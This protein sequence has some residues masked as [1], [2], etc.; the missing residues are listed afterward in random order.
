MTRSTTDNIGSRCFAEFLGT[1]ILVFAGCGAII[2]DQATGAAESGVGALGHLGVSVVFGLAVLAVIYAF[3]EISGAHINP[4]VTVAFWWSGRFPG[5]EVVPYALSQIAG[6]AVASFTLMLCLMQTVEYTTWGVTLP[7]SGLAS[8]QAFALETILTFILMTVIIHVASGS[9]ETGIMAG[10]AIGA[11]VLILA[12]IGGPVTGASMNPARTLGPA[13]AFMTFD[14]IW[15]YLTAPIVGAVLA[16]VTCR[17]TRG[18]E[19]ECC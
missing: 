3:G 9:K 1:F 19:A 2:I 7:H 10:S 18:A 12:L 17:L 8:W 6:A 5:R 4:A 13:L 16:T 11:S 14:Q 15:I